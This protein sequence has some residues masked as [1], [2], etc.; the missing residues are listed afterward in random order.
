MKALAKAKKLKRFEDGGEVE[1]VDAS[2]AKT[3]EQLATE[4][5]ETELK[6]MRDE[7][8]AADESSTPSKPEFKSFKEAYAWHRKNEGQGS[9]FDYNGKKILV[10]D[11]ARKEAAKP[12]AAAPAEAAKPKYQSLQDRAKSYEDARAKSG[13]GMY[14]TTKSAPKEERK[15][16]PLKSTKSET[17]NSFMGSVKYAKGGVVARATVK[18]H[19]KAC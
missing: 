3:P 4:A 17:G 13:V 2:P 6:R 15:P 16:L 11:E 5:G 14:G 18:S 1:V 10:K 7:S 8:A 12:A 9:T 19:G